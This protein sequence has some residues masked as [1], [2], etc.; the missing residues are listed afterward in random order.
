MKYLKIQNK[1]ELDLRL[2]SLMGGTTKTGNGFKI[3]RFGTGLKYSL[4]WLVR[5]NIDFKIFIG[6]H[7]VKV[8]TKTEH[9]QGTDFDV[10]YIDGERSSIASSTGIDWVGWMIVREIYCNAVDEGGLVREVTDEVLGAEETTTFYL[11]LTGEIEE[12]VEHWGDYFV[13]DIEPMYSSAEFDIYPGGK[14]LRIYKQGVLIKCIPDAHALFNYDIKNAAINE[15][16]EYTGFTDWDIST[17]L[18]KSDKKIADFAISNMTEQNYEGK[19]DYSWH[20]VKYSDAW[21]EVIGNAKLI[22]QK[23]V[24]NLAAREIEIDRAAN[25]V[26]PKN[27]LLSLTR[28]FDGI[29]TLR[30]SDAIGTFYETNCP[31][32]KQRVERSIEILESRGYRIRHE[33]NFVYGVFEDKTKLAE[34]NLDKHEVLFSEALIKF[35]LLYLC[36]VL[37]EENEHFIT[38]FNDCSRSL[39]THFIGM[40]VQK[41]LENLQIEV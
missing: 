10:I 29:S 15:L 28:Q 27:L 6:T 9:I 34:T 11:Q 30:V 2:I 36:G 31:E 21:R 17:A 7:E 12:T 19:M 22:S 18:S 26:V 37:V 8:T 41:L 24:D 5:N 38:G 39:Q 33:L 32:L 20:S 3:G 14:D 40:F 4:A 35:P 13:H 16:R 1:G 23:T 25:I